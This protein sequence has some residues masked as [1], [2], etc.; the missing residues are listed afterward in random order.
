MTLPLPESRTLA[1][2]GKVSA[3]NEKEWV[4][5]FPFRC[6]LAIIESRIGREL[7]SEKTAYK[8]DRELMSTIESLDKELEQWRNAI[9]L[10][11]RPQYGDHL[12]LKVDAAMIHFAYY[13]CLISIHRIS[14]RRHLPRSSPATAIRADDRMG[15]TE[16]TNGNKPSSVICMNAARASI[17]LLSQIPARDSGCV[18]YFNSH[19][20]LERWARA[21][22]LSG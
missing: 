15:A 16:R 9:P 12:L 1:T 22:G 2:I 6:A 7:Y 5:L 13:N 11:M 8:S 20:L 10:G 18:W 19:P 3:C 21:H 17:S 4:D 14:L